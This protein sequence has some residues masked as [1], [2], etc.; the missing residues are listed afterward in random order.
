MGSLRL[1]LGLFIIVGGGYAALKLMPP[2]FDN[3]QF[4]DAIKDEA[5]H[6]TYSPKTENDIRDTVFKLAQQNDIPV[7]LEGIQVQRQGSQYNGMIIIH[8][9]YVVHVDFLVYAVDLHFEA[10]T[11]NKSVF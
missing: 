2:Y 9:P 3:Y 1:L 7:A 10:G 8:V 6:D 4:Q 11:Q 5:T